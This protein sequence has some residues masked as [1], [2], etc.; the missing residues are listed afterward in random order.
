MHTRLARFAWGVL[1][2]N[3][4]VILWGAYVRASGSG[5]GCG[6]HWPFCNGEVLPRD[7]GVATIIEFSHRATSGLALLFVVALL[8][9]TLRGTRAGHPARG[10]A[11]A[12]LFFMLTE[13]AVGAGLVLFRLV[14]DNA[15]MARALFMAAHLMNTFI[16]VGCLTLTAYWLSGGVP[17]RVRGAGWRGG[18]VALGLAAL[19]LTGISGAVAALGDTLFPAGSLADALWND[20]SPTSHLLIRL[21]V[22]HPAI[23]I[24]TGVLIAF[25]APRL[26]RDDAGSLAPVCRCGGVSGGPS[27]RRRDRKRHSPCADLDAARPPAGCRCALDCLRAPFG[28]RARERPARQ[29]CCSRVSDG[30]PASPFREGI[31][32]GPKM[33]SRNVQA[34]SEPS[35]NGIGDVRTTAIVVAVTHSPLGPIHVATRGG[36]L[37]ALSFEDYW[38]HEQ[39]HLVRRFGAVRLEPGACTEAVAAVDRYFAGETAALD[40]VAAEPDGTPFQARVWRALRQIPAGRTMSYRD[41]AA[42]IG[43]P[44]AVRA[45]AAANGRNPIPLIIPCHRVIGADGRLVGYGGGLER[46]AWLLR[47]EGVFV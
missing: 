25:G 34:S 9:W 41:L 38:A 45:V 40:A 32:N 18:A 3:I 7:P 35:M 46:K 39:Q 31:E 13:A 21:R 1:S 11:W 8:V 24:G 33:R 6:S 47:H 12:S 44:T 16:L 10:A 37:C 2:Y 28:A 14:A 29:R 36:T 20:L 22:L 42:S 5:A 17:V 4:A 26:L 23:A 15:T 30:G 43:E 19:I 27:A